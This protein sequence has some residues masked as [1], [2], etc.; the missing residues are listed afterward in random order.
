MK[1]GKSNA[2]SILEVLVAMTMFSIVLPAI[3]NEFFVCMRVPKI[4][5]DAINLLADVNNC[6]TNVDKLSPNDTDI[7]SMLILQTETK[8]VTESWNFLGRKYTRRVQ[9]Q[10]T[11]GKKFKAKAKKQAIFGIGNKTLYLYEITILN[12]DSLRSRP[13]FTVYHY[14]F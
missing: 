3:V 5:Q 7:H 1:G 11:E 2:F 9:K 12:H 6:V 4:D 10:I 13:S 14:D 8:W